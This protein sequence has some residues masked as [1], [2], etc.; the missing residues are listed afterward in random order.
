[1]K[2]LNIHKKSYQK[3]SLDFTWSTVNP[4]RAIKIGVVF[5]YPKEEREDAKQPKDYI[6]ENHFEQQY[7]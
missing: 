4:V 5:F 6:Q 3:N 7:R 1:M 2:K